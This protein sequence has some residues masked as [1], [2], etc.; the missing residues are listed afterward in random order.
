MISTTT[1]AFKH[2]EIERDINVISKAETCVISKYFLILVGVLQVLRNALREGRGVIENITT[3]LQRG[4]RGLSNVL[5]LITV[6]GASVW[7]QMEAKI[8]K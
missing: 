2:Q 1:A 6:Q 4:G 5:L 3:A 7:P 8:S